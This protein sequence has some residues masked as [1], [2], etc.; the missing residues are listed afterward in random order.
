[1]AEL[2]GQLV[3]HEDA[4]AG[5]GLVVDVTTGGGLQLDAVLDRLPWRSGLT[6]DLGGLPWPGPPHPRGAV[7][8]ADPTAPLPLADG[9]AGVLL[10]VFAG[11]V[12]AEAERL[13]TPAGLLVVAR[14]TQAHLAE[15]VR[16][17]A[18]LGVTRRLPSHPA[19]AVGS[20]RRGI[21]RAVSAQVDLDHG[22]IERLVDAE[23]GSLGRWLRGVRDPVRVT[24]SVRLSV[25]RRRQFRTAS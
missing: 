15:L 9:A 2:I 16:P 4:A 23:P 19:A 11:L 10:D 12:P 5:D 22:D 17:L 1:M 21:T 3:L 8:A 25:Y 20:L 24:L 18:V 14:P 7:I 13:L 6:L